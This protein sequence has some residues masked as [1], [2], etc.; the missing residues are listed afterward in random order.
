MRK[1][2]SVFLS[3]VFILISCTQEVSQTNNFETL[4]AAKVN[5]PA[6]IDLTVVPDSNSPQI[7]CLPVETGII[8][9]EKYGLKGTVDYLDDIDEEKSFVENISC[10]FIEPSFILEQV[11]GTLSSKNGDSFNFTGTVKMDISSALTSKTVAVEGQLTLT[12]GTGKFAGMSGSI[13]TNGTGNMVNG[14]ISWKGDGY[15]AYK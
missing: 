11:K 9:P 7:K 5:I 8:L 4:K 15:Y 2:L 14:A 3:S 12:S 1:L 10:E 6:S 13:K